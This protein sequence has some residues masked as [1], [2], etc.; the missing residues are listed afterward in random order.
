MAIAAARKQASKSAQNQILRRPRF[1]WSLV[2]ISRG[3]AGFPSGG[4][5]SITHRQLYAA[6]EPASQLHP[7]ATI[8]KTTKNIDS[9]PDDDDCFFV[10]RKT[11]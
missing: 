10:D 4:H 8:S 1:M 11:L 5:T 3:K 7:A 2:R 9:G 6:A